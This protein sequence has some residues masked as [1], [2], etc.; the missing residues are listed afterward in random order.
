MFFI[1]SLSFSSL[2]HICDSF[3]EIGL[4]GTG[5]RVVKADVEAVFWK[6]RSVAL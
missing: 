1:D 2:K 6:R 5:V 4:Q 3:D